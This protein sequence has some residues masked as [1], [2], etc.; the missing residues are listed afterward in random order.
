MFRK[1]KT[2]DGDFFQNHPVLKHHNFLFEKIKSTFVPEDNLLFLKAPGR[3]NLIGE[4]TD[5]NMGPVLPCAIDKEIVFCIR[6]CETQEIKV[7]NVNHKFDDV[8]F[9]FKLGIEPFSK[10]HWGNYIKAGIKGIIDYLEATSPDKIKYFKGF[11]AVVS[12]TLPTAAGVS[13]SSALMVA[14]ALSF[15]SVNKLDLNKQKIAEI[16]AK[17]EHFVGT[18]GGGMDQAASLLAKENSFLKI[19]FNPLRIEQISAPEDI[20]LVLF[21]SMEKA[22]KSGKAQIE[23]NRRVLECRMGVDLFNRFIQNE[24]KGDYPGINYI[25]EIKTDLFNLNNDELDLLVGRFLND[26]PDAYSILEFTTVMD[27]NESELNERYRHILLGAPL[28]EPADGFKILSRFRHV[29]SECQRVDNT[30]KCLR[31]RDMS[32]LGELLNQSH[33]SL[34]QYYEVSTSEVDKLVNILR[35]NGAFGARIMGAG[36]GGMVLAYTEASMLEHLIEQAK[37]LYYHEKRLQNFNNL[38]FPCIAVQ[39]AG[40]I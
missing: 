34:S 28:K 10:G 31:N 38:I 21:H 37:K 22:E 3:V 1:C 9:S 24:L 11:E 15:V 14:S 33:D 13:S 2:L 5:Y 7:S 36:F 29:Y 16:C 35:E 19:D 23:Y 32:V 12:S 4:H 39:G 25:G 20:Q 30:V 27:L 18:A 17:A 40:L 8:G 6:P 26:L